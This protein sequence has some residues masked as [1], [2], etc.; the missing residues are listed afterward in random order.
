MKVLK[1]SLGMMEAEWFITLITRE[2]FDYT[3]WRQGLC[4]YMMVKK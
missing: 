2:P 3:Q 1:K 4:E